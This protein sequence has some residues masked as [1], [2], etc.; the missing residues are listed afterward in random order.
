L[1]SSRKN[2]NSQNRYDVASNDCQVED[3]NSQFPPLELSG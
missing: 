3:R 2:A 1:F